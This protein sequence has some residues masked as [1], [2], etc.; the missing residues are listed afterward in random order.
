MAIT[1][2]AVFFTHSAYFLVTFMSGKVEAL[3][4][5]DELG[6]H[7]GRFE[8]IAL[9]KYG[10]I[11]SFSINGFGVAVF[12]DTFRKG[13]LI[14]EDY[15]LIDTSQPIFEPKEAVSQRLFSKCLL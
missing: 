2:T 7:A 12:R 11:N 15:D 5:R 1:R 4:R 3:M 13:P 9:T 8:V 14:I 6:K 10:D